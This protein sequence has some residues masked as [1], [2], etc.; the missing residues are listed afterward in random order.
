MSLCEQNIKENTQDCLSKFF[1]VIEGMIKCL[2][3]D[4]AMVSKLNLQNTYELKTA[5][6]RPEFELFDE[7]FNFL[8]AGFL[9]LILE[10]EKN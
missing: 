8:K 10:I 4:N 6:K 3:F 7:K 9:E 2:N 1:D 5:G